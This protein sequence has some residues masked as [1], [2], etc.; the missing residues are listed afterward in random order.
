MKDMPENVPYIVHES[1]M[2]RMERQVKRAFVT[3]IIALVA[4]FASNAIWVY[5]WCQ[6]DYVSES[7]EAEQDGSGVNII[8]GGDVTYGPESNDSEKEKD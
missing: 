4:M 5:A 8:G 1:S 7:I 3:A 2:A 6:Y